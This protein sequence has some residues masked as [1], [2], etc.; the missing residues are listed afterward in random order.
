[1]LTLAC[2]DRAKSKLHCIYPCGFWDDRSLT[3]YLP[4]GE[5]ANQI[6]LV[7]FGS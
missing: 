1:M 6:A 3:W 5:P 4:L 2:C 7:T